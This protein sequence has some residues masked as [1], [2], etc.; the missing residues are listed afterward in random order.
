MMPT[1]LLAGAGLASYGGFVCFAL[2]MPAHWVQATGTPGDAVSGRRRLRP[3]G[4]LM[5]GL[6]YVLCVCR[7]GPGFGSLLWGVLMSAA[8]IAVALTLT[9]RPTCLLPTVS[10]SRFRDA[11]ADRLAK[12][13]QGKT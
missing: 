12:E 13:E 8:A 4:A 11:E 10:R 1:L 9:W 5:L 7:D 6:A 2:A 3:A